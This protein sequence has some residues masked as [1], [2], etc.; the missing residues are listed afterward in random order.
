MIRKLNRVAWLSALGFREG[1]IV[2]SIC[3]NSSCLIV[4]SYM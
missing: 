3:I 1:Y 4:L 2:I